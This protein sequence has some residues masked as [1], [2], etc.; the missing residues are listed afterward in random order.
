MK[1]KVQSNNEYSD[2]DSGS[3]SDFTSKDITRGNK[4]VY[5]SL[6]FNKSRV[7]GM[8]VLNINSSVV[9]LSEYSDS[10]NFSV[11][12][13]MIEAYSPGRIIVPKTTLH[14]SS[15]FEF[16]PKELMI[17]EVTLPKNLWSESVGIALVNKLS[18]ETSI[19]IRNEVHGKSICLSCLAALLNHVEDIQKISFVPGSLIIRFKSAEGFMLLDSSTVIHLELISSLHEKDSDDSNDKKRD[20]KNSV[21]S[22]IDRTLTP[23]GKRMLRMNLLQPFTDKDTILHRQKALSDILSYEEEYFRGKEILSAYSYDLD[24]IIS[25]FSREK[26][27]VDANRASRMIQNLLAIKTCLEDLE[28]ITKLLSTFSS[29]L[30]QSLRET[31]CYKS[32]NILLHEI[33]NLIDINASFSASKDINQCNTCFALKTGLNEFLDTTRE[34]YTELHED[35]YEL[36]ESLRSESGFGNIKI[37]HSQKRG[38]YLSIE[39]TESNSIHLPN[40]FIQVYKYKRRIMF[41]TLEL[42]SLNTRLREVTEDILQLTMKALEPLVQK[43]RN[44][45]GWLVTVSESI[46]ILDVL[47][48][49]A[50]VVCSASIK[51]NG[52]SS[53]SIPHFSENGPVAIKTG[54]HPLLSKSIGE[55]LVVPNDFFLSSSHNF[56]I[57][58]G[59]NQSGKSTALKTLGVIQILA[60]IGGSVP[61]VYASLRYFSHV[62]TRIG[63]D[64]SIETNASS[65]MVEMREMTNII[66]NSNSSSLILIDE[67]GR[68]TSNSDAAAISFAICEHLISKEAFTCFVTH[69]PQITELE[70][71]YPNVKNLHTVVRIPDEGQI[72]FVYEIRNGPCDLDGYGLR[73]AKIMGFPKELIDDA[74][75]IYNEMKQTQNPKVISKENVARKICARIV[76]LCNNSS[77]NNETWKDSASK[78]QKNISSI[79]QSL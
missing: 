69:I 26:K 6:A 19:S 24:K 32:R 47:Y 45:I 70:Y 20:E 73:L 29:P 12:K 44:H 10:S 18:S 71:I 9:I 52:A 78:L 27:V 55:K 35:I 77:M 17:H 60:Q 33:E 13:N 43:I 48:S 16:I 21:L 30:L 59:A 15:V 53:W 22:M 31:I 65:F 63:N 76:S 14:D 8:A 79:M 61:A 66:Q 1:R 7:V 74:H 75:N 3:D 67:L 64:D 57:L 39:N 28:E 4:H 56:A 23:M 68:S 36:L 72:E 50:T 34:I 41:S 46:G 2:S 42:N 49:F 11:T 62:F 37:M 58:T 54:Q 25:S 38:F 51:E 40:T 5:I